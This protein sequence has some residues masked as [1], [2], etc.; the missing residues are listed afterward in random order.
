MDLWTLRFLSWFRTYL[1]L[2]WEFILTVPAFA[3][4]A[5]GLL[6]CWASVAEELAGED[7]GKN[8]PNDIEYLSLLHVPGN[9]VSHF[10]PERAHIFTNVE[11][12]FFCCP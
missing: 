2:W 4:L 5:K 10:F 6:Q 9:Q 1:P 11:E 12:A 8:V 7:Q 3:T